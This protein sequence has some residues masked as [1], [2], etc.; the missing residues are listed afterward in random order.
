LSWWPL[1]LLLLAAVLGFWFLQ[2]QGAA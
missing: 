2:W 1:A